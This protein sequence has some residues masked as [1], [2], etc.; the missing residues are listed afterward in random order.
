MSHSS[1][2]GWWVAAILALCLGAA[3]ALAQPPA[4]K[5]PAGKAPAGK[6]PAQQAAPPV[7]LWWN[8][9]DLVTTLSLR[10]D[11]RTKMDQLF[12]K[13]G[14]AA[15]GR[16]SVPLKS[17]AEYFTALREGD[18]ERARKQLSAWA[19]QESAE[20]RAAGELRIE[21]LSLLDAEQRKILGKMTPAIANLAWVPRAAW[22]AQE[23]PP[24]WPGAKPGPPGKPGAPAPAPRPA[25]R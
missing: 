13:H 11:Q 14:R 17:R 19:E 5:A 25:E 7:H 2:A 16:P 18:M 24:P 8:D 20:I 1:S 22:R 3:P 6:A 10:A 9:S 15:P 4:E 23:Q 12:E 21:I